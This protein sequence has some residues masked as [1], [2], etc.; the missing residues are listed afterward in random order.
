MDDPLIEIKVKIRQ[1][2]LGKFPPAGSNAARVRLQC[3]LEPLAHGGIRAGGFDLGNQH[4]P[5][6]KR[7]GKKKKI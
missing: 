7:R 4:N 5:K 3:G 1:S 2:E 6:I